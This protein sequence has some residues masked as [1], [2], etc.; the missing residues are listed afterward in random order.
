VSLLG[1]TH[2]LLVEAA[3]QCC[4]ENTV[5]ATFQF[6]AEHGYRLIDTTET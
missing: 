2:V 5:A 4:F 3:V 1:E 6:M